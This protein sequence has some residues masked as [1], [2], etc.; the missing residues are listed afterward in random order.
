MS[1]QACTASTG[2]IFGVQV[3]YCGF[4]A[5]QWPWNW[6]LAFSMTSPTNMTAFFP[7]PVHP[8]HAVSCIFSCCVKLK[9]LREG[10]PKWG[11]LLK[12][13][14]FMCTRCCVQL[15][16]H[17]NKALKN[18]PSFF[19]DWSQYVHCNKTICDSA[20]WHIASDWLFFFYKLH[21]HVTHLIWMAVHEM[22]LF[23][24]LYFPVVRS[25]SEI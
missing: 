1:V 6:I 8:W 13:V 4:V 22:T 9:E 20:A 5:Y 10:T 24:L 11:G 7:W 16:K 3:A 14:H 19:N 17:V 18:S 21:A 12:F 15:Y 25:W 23:L 2:A